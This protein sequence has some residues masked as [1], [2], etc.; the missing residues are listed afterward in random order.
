MARYLAKNIVASGLCDNAKVTLGYM[1]GIPEPSSIDIEMNR[2]MDIATDLSE[3]LRKNVDL[4]PKR[5]IDRFNGTEPKNTM[6]AIGGHYGGVD[7]FLNSGDKKPQNKSKK[8][9]NWEILDICEDIKKEFI[10]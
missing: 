2:N 4:T 1:I 5:I 7:F 9:R 10:K 6:T 3:W 8:I